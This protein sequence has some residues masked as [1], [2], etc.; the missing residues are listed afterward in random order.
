MNIF[1]FVLHTIPFV[2]LIKSRLNKLSLLISW[3]ISYVFVQYIFVKIFNNSIN[4]FDFI[5]IFTFLI[6]IYELGYVFND[7][8]TIKKEKNPTLRFSKNYLLLL[9]KKI[10]YLILLNILYILILIVIIDKEYLDLVFYF[11]LMIILFFIFHNNIKNNL[12][13]ITF[14]FLNHCKN[15]FVPTILV[16]ENFNIE[17]FIELNILIFIIFTFYRSI[18]NLSLSRFN[19]KYLKFIN[20]NRHFFRVSYYFLVI[21]FVCTIYIYNLNQTYINFIYLLT[22]LLIYRIIT[23]FMQK[24]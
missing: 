22:F 14:L 16:I 5:L 8:Y 11:S 13:I 21:I 7:V 10:L 24:Y 20:D 19:I 12:N 4:I 18:E 6:N 17:L 2:Y 15:I 1:K 3:L 9:E 23:T